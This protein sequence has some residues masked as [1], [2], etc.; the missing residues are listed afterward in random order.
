MK[1]FPIKVIS[2]QESEVLQVRF[3]PTDI[4]NYN[5][6]Y[7]F[8]GSHDSTYRYPK[9]ID[10]V[11]VNF[12]KLFDLYTT[13]LGKTRFD[14]MIAGGGEPTMWPHL[15]QFCKEIKKTHNVYITIVTNGSRTLRWWEENSDCFDAAVLSCHNEFVD[16]DHYKSVADLLFVKGIKITAQMLMDAKNWKR[17]VDYIDQMKTSKHPWMIETKPVVDA[18]GHGVDVYTSDQLEYINNN[19]KR[20]PDSDWILK[21]FEKFKIH[22]SAVLFNDGSAMVAKSHEIITNRWNKF[23][24]WQ[25]NI[26]IEAIAIEPSGNVIGSCRLQIL[27]KNINMFQEDFDVTARPKKII[28]SLSEC[29]CQPDTHATKTKI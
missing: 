3:F 10:L 28:C 16:I 22:N 24:G 25:C 1:R 14:L 7:C 6:S 5:C 9:N 15:E 18:P 11:I 27:D 29:F 20:V 8:P 4:C 12:K 13:T 19:L 23:N 2:T 21:N 26:G 17:C